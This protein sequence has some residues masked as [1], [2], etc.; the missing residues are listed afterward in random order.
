M[1]RILPY[2]YSSIANSCKLGRTGRL[3]RNKAIE[4]HV[5]IT[6]Q[7]EL[8]YSFACLACSALHLIPLTA[9][10][11]SPNSDTLISMCASVI[12]RNRQYAYNNDVGTGLQVQ[13]LGVSL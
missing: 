8:L 2:V 6:R 4:R 1:I 3:E 9:S 12:M 5:S 10:A 7:N 11:D 13:L